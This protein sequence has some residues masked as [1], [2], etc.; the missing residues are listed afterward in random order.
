MPRRQMAG[1]K[2]KQKQGCHLGSTLPGVSTLDHTPRVSL[3]HAG[4]L[5]PT[6][7]GGGSKVDA[8]GGQL[9]LSVDT[10]PPA[11]T[12]G[13]C[14]IRRD[15]CECTQQGEHQV[16]PKMSQS[17]TYETPQRPTSGYLG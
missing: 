4:S 10:G 8:F 11:S 15:G 5:G 2:N 14:S 7:A 9:G 16:S 12:W 6:L 3:P 17:N 1:T 13:S